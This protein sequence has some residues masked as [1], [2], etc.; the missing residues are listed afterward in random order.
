MRGLKPDENEEILEQLCD[1][2]REYRGRMMVRSKCQPQLMRHVYERDHDSS[3]LHYQTRCPCGVQ[4]C[5]ITPEGKVTPCPYMPEVAGDLTARTFGDIWKD[6]KIFK[7]L[8]N[9]DLGGK[10]GR[11]EYR[12]VCGGCRARAYAVD[13]DFL[14]PDLSC[15]YEPAPGVAPIVPVTRDVMYGESP[16][17]GLP[18]SPEAEAR[19]SSI[20]SFVR[21]VVGNRIEKF[22]IEAGYDLVTL[23][24]MSEVRKG[25]PIDFSKRMPFFARGRSGKLKNV[26][27]TSGVAETRPRVENR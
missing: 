23:E 5:R 11:C 17:L 1:L 2:Q 3:L 26:E 12:E 6:A 22:A 14:G 18:W 10:C 20:P 21:G 19:L 16:T 7:L 9:G 13:G 24:V 8:R 15:A 27:T 25:M 4:Y